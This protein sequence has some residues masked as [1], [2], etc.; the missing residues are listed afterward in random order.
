MFNIR[1]QVFCDGLMSIKMQFSE[2]FVTKL[3]IHSLKELPNLYQLACHSPALRESFPVSSS[4]FTIA[5]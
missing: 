5:S 1:I 2:Y 4:R 3:L